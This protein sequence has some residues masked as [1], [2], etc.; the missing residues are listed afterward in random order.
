MWLLAAGGMW[1]HRGVNAPSHSVRIGSRWIFIVAYFAGPH[2]LG[3]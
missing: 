2:S 1:R 3:I